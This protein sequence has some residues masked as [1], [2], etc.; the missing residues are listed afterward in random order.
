VSVARRRS[1]FLVLLVAIAG[2][3]LALSAC[4]FFKEKSLSVSQPGGIGAA[5]VHFVLCTEPSGTT[6]EPNEK[7]EPPE[8][9]ETIQYLIGIAVPRGA[10]PPS[11]FTAQPITSGTQPITFTRNDQVASEM[12][13]ASA[14]L[15]EAELPPEEGA[16]EIKPWP[17]A[18]LEGFGYLSNPV[19]EEEGSLDEWAVDAEFGL[20]VPSDG[21]PFTGPFSAATAEGARQV[22][23]G[24]PADSSVHC[25]RFEGGFEEGEAFCGPTVEEVQAGTSDLKIAA[26][27]TAPVFV[28]GKATLPFSLN[29]GSTAASAPTFNVTATATL[30]GAGVTVSSPSFTPPAVDPGTHRSSGGETI[31]VAVPPTAKPGLYEVTVSAKTPQG[32]TATQVAKF[33]VTKPKLKIG[34]AKL[35][36]HNGT[37]KLSIGVPSAG[38]LTVSGKGIAKVKRSAKGPKTLKVTIKAKGKAKKTLTSTG[39]AKVK[40]K[41]AFQPSNGAAVTKKKSIT[42]KKKLG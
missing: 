19:E 37:A 14:K 27:P 34:K 2:L 6:C 5:R 22:S 25:W 12:A 8:G 35:N 33:E 39:N 3:A 26:P 4:A 23:P 36:K 20:P 32:G 21:S 41:I 28:G 18:G 40:A 31:T 29:F 9:N 42:L 30:P 16:E 38:T 1:K 15:A 11:T 17:P 7:N 13:A 24:H 10:A